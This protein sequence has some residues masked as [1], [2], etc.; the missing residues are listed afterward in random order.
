MSHDHHETPQR[1]AATPLIPHEALRPGSGERNL[2]DMKM[3]AAFADMTA[4]Y[5]TM[6][7]NANEIATTRKTMFD[8]YI[9][10]GF[11][12]SQSLELVKGSLL[13]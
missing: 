13:P 8:A 9:K 6:R 2:G 5:R 7:D 12:E 10:A 3:A 11:T 1:R 4:L